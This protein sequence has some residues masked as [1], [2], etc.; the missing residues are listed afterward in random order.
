MK[1]DVAS[2]AG[3]SD[4]GAYACKLAQPGSTGNRLVLDLGAITIANTLAVKVFGRGCNNK[5][6]TM[7]VWGGGKA[8]NSMADNNYAF[9]FLFDA[10]ATLG[11]AQPEAGTGS[12]FGSDAANTF[13]VDSIAI[14]NEAA[15][16]PPGL[17][18]IGDIADAIAQLQLDSIGYKYI[19]LE[20]TFTG[21]GNGATAIGILWRTL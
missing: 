15:P 16:T 17:K 6:A 13:F 1:V 12:I 18:L 11:A 19:I 14:T 3:L 10:T 8:V 9:D 21:T 2:S 5:E 4:E 20:F 7:R